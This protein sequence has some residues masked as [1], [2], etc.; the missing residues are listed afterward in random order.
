VDGIDSGDRDAAGL[1][2]AQKKAFVREA[3]RCGYATLDGLNGGGK[4]R[5]RCDQE[6]IRAD[7]KRLIVKTNGAGGADHAGDPGDLSGQDSHAGQQEFLFSCCAAGVNR[8]D[9][10]GSAD[11]PWAGICVPCHCL[12]RFSD[13][14]GRDC[15]PASPPSFQRGRRICSNAAWILRLSNR[16][17]RKTFKTRGRSCC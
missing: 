16:T 6:K 1:P 5:L 7:L 9:R 10:S 15:Q 17:R 2:R 8:A 14:H 12:L 4:G 11:I 13:S 3:R